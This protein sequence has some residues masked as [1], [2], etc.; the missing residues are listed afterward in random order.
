MDKKII[1][2]Y[3]AGY[4]FFTT[5][6]YCF[7][8][9]ILVLGVYGLIESCLVDMNILTIIQSVFIFLVLIF[10]IVLIVLQ[11]REIIRYKMIITDEYIYL[12]ANRDL[13][14]TRHKDIKMKYDNII[15]LQ[16]EKTIRPDLY[17]K[18]QTFFSAIYIKRSNKKKEDMLL[19][20]WFSKK[21]TEEIMRLI[22]ENAEKINRN[23]VEI[24]S[25][26]IK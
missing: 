16:Y 3:G 7:L 25:P 12:A 15:S 13:F 2:P 8:L 19:T 9:G 11:T 5:F 21:Q 14:L 18:G 17:E 23:P 22:K 26:I 4:I 24:L 1:Q 6:K 20:M 10:I